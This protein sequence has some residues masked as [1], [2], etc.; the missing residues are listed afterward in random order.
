MSV[1]EPFYRLDLSRVNARYIDVTLE[2]P[3]QA[4]GCTL[5]L[6]AWI[7]GSYL[8]R[9]F[10]KN[11]VGMAATS[12]SGQVVPLV[13]QDQSTWTLAACPE[14]VVIQYHVYCADFSVRTAHA[15][16]RHAFFNGS[17][18]FLRVHGA[19]HQAHHL[20]LSAN[21]VPAAWRVATSM[22]SYSLDNR[23][24]GRYHA[25]DYE[26]LIDYPFELGE[27]ELLDW[28]SAGVPHR[29]ALSNAH[30]RTD[31]A[32]IAR[33]VARICHTEIDFFCEAP[34]DQ[35]LFLVALDTAGF[36]GLEH[37]DST[38][39]I[40][41]R[42]DLPLL[43]ETGISPAYQRFLSLCAHE[44]FHAWHVKRIRPQAFTQLPLARPAHTRLLWLFEGFTSYFDDWL[45]RR[46]GLIDE[47]AYLAALTQTINRAVR[48]K[49]WSRQTLEES[50]FYAWTR[51]YQQDENA[52]NAIVSYYTRGALVAL[53][54]DLLLR[55]RGSSLAWAMRQLWRDF[56]A[57]PLPEG[58]A[59]EQYFATLAAQCPEDAALSAFFERALRSVEPLDF[60]ALLA[61]FGV[62][63]EPASEPD[64]AQHDLGAVVGGDDPR[65]AKVQ[66][67]FEDR[68]AATA[69]LAVGDEIIALDGWAISGRT[70]REQLRRYRVGDQITLHGFR[71]GR[72]M[73]WSLTLAPPVCNQWALH[74]GS[75]NDAA[76]LARRADWLAVA[77]LIN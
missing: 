14:P 46:A 64:F 76:I 50:S 30:P 2:L 29:M 31:F 19:E 71:Q 24:F 77:E 36:G 53:M 61:E 66:L 3:A 15:D 27:F 13:P 58:A 6:P 10:A 35:Y 68:P 4:A 37:R 41:P 52:V 42:H 33:D 45:V 73:Q 1:V 11:L 67:V 65:C 48:G 23:G 26:S 9:D 40:F 47:S 39:L 20:D 38:A 32:R 16:S 59:I 55:Q 60:P 49:G 62:R 25:A 54:L 44:Y 21:Q 22:P 63:A 17:S 70:W 57:C 5:S 34:F 12:A 69:G 43:G 28:I 75:T 72:L 18:I 56:G 8:I 7:P 74:L 51:F